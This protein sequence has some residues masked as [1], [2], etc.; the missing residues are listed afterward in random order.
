MEEWTIA[1]LDRAIEEAKAVLDRLTTL[2]SQLQQ[3][4]EEQQ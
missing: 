4:A 2:R 1:V 3:L